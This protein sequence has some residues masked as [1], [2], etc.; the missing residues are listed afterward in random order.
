M[1]FEWSPIQRE[2]CDVCIN[3][4]LRQYYQGMKPLPHV[5]GGR[6]V[7]NKFVE[8]EAKRKQKQK[9]RLRAVVADATK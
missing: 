1:F 7:F 8:K 2:W 6:E 3:C 9:H 4:G 5:N